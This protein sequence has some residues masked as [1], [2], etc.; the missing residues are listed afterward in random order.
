M[1]HSTLPKKQESAR[2]QDTQRRW[3]GLRT[4]NGELQVAVDSVANLFTWKKRI[5][6]I[7]SGS[8]TVQQI[9]AVFR[10]VL[11]G[12]Q[13]ASGEGYSNNTTCVSVKIARSIVVVE[14]KTRRGAEKAKQNFWPEWQM[15]VAVISED[16]ACWNASSYTHSTREMALYP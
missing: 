16:F 4:T 15:N 13:E 8:I 3:Q 10:M 7:E 5:R 9:W 1:W 11:S 2:V 6:S 12:G 14:V